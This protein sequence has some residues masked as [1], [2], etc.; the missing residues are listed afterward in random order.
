MGGR[1]LGNYF[2]LAAAWIAAGLLYTSPLVAEGAMSPRRV[3]SDSYTVRY[4]EVEVLEVIRF[5]S[6]VAGVNF[7]YQ[8]EDLQFP[9][10]IVSERAV[11]AK[12]LLNLLLQVLQSHGF[13]ISEC[14]ESLFIHK[15]EERM[16]MASV[17]TGE[18][19][20][21]AVVTRVFTLYNL[22]PEKLRDLI[23][24][25][26]S[27]T[28]SVNVLSDSHHLI[29]TDL[30][31]NVDKVADL[32]EALDS[33]PPGIEI[34]QYA[35]RHQDPQMLT[36]AVCN[37]LRPIVS[38]ATFSLV[39]QPGNDT[40]FVVSTPALI[41]R[42]LSLLETLDLPVEEQL[43]EA[44]ITEVA[45]EEDVVLTGTVR[46]FEMGG[47]QM[48]VYKVQYH[49]GDSV[50][51]SL[52]EISRSLSAKGVE[53][54]DLIE[55]AMHANWVE[56]TNT[57]IF[58]GDR[59]GIQKLKRLLQEVDT[60]LKQVFI[61]VLVLRTRLNDSLE[62]G[63]DWGERTAS[64]EPNGV[65]TGVGMAQPGSHL[66]ALL[67]PLH[68]PNTNLMPP[69]KLGL[70]LG[71]IGRFVSKNG[72]NFTSL[73]ALINAVES[74]GTAQVVINP[75]LLAQD[76]QTASI[77]VGENI[78]FVDNVLA[79]PGSTL[80]SQNIS[81]RD[82]GTTLRIT[83]LLGSEEAITLHIDQ[84][85]EETVAPP[86]QQAS[87]IP[88]SKSFTKTRVHVPNGHF[89]ILS[90][91]IQQRDRSHRSGLPCLGGLPV[92]GA[93]FANRRE[94]VEKENLIIFI[95]P[96]LVDTKEAIEEVTQTQRAKYKRAS[97]GKSRRVEW[98]T[99]LKLL[100]LT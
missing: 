35:V 82:V 99:A 7:V 89:V 20:S 41:E 3:T 4:H 63:V 71:V 52:I 56:D 22:N 24:P 64:L 32:I 2:V 1:A 84:E 81:Y 19:S 70:G 93:A 34:A 49:P 50:K 100:N 6:R 68:P 25:M 27:S 95:R 5:V 44:S 92:L 30:S 72:L 15:Q 46:E 58:S 21:R 43:L 91:Q 8:E 85:I 57:L 9:V 47:T 12:E 29:L 33:P 88:T 73:G 26:L 78:A 66:P 62:F 37:M 86:P 18:S 98:C 79:E 10:T 42:T 97:H 65:S 11:N 60:P 87:S 16:R 77:F 40:L 75:T 31:S 94:R 38:D 17:V 14:E 69:D 23:T 74:D 96:H 53:N 61:E 48:L 39:P 28:A 80:T 67:D 76:R 59:R 36:S 45:E 55:T 51:E 13:T 83:P 54:N 90:G